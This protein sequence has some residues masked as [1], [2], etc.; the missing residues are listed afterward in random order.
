MLI[1]KV[2]INKNQNSNKGLLND[3]DYLHLNRSQLQTEC[4]VANKL[5][6][7]IFTETLSHIENVLLKFINTSERVNIK[8][9]LSENQ[10]NADMADGISDANANEDFMEILKLRHINLAK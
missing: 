9:G 3:K 5:N 1:D 4:F 8:Y 2:K 7:F 10:N 6:K